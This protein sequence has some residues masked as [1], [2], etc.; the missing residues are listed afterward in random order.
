MLGWLVCVRTPTRGCGG[1]R[2]RPSLP[3]SPFAHLQSLTECGWIGMA[4]QWVPETCL[5]LLLPS[6][7]RRPSPW[8]TF[9]VDGGDVSSGPYVRQ[10]PY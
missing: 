9:Y 6:R 4:D 5:A 8:V 1:Q 3:P 10:A 2:A 7:D